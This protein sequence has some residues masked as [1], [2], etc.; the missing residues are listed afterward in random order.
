VL[1]TI[2][3]FLEKDLRWTFGVVFVIALILLLADA[4]KAQNP[5]ESAADLGKGDLSGGPG[6]RIADPNQ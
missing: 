4:G 3:G 1:G 5:Y 6:L 2:V